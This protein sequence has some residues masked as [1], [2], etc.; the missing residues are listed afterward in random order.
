[1]R[2]ERSGA[3]L[4]EA[5]DEN[6]R[7]GRWRAG[8]RIP[9]ERALSEAFGISRTTV[10]RVL[11]G[12][13]ARRLI[14]QV[15]GSGTYVGTDLS[16]LLQAATAPSASGVA[17][18]PAELMEAR[19]ALEP[20]IVQ[21][22]IRAGTSVDFDRMEVCCKNAEAA[23]TLEAFEQWD[24]LL[25]EAIAEAAHNSMILA[26]FRLINNARGQEEWGMLKKRSVT[27][28]RR[29]AYQA[30]HRTL[31]RALRLRDLEAARDATQAHLAHVRR[32]L[33]GY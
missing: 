16:R 15:V 13:K 26:V 31:V 6:F 17:T 9:T 5:I 18:S 8:H 27:P 10:R 14:S 2:Q 7:S 24:G 30:E 32:N 4:E 19:L 29:L 33:L 25:H 1:M 11:A 12:Y 20:A 3:A 22:V 21:M 28:E 23:I